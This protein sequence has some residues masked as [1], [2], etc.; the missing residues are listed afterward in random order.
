MLLDHLE[1]ILHY[2]RTKVPMGVVEVVN[3]SVRA[4]LRRRRGYR[5]MKSA[6]EG[7]ALGCY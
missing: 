1:A 6:A 5:D 2:C 4:L 3:G 7:A